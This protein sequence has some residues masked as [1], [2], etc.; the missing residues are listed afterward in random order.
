MLST[1]VGKFLITV[2]FLM[3]DQFYIM[4]SVNLDFVTCG[5][6]SYF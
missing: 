5:L 3:T 4:K 2:L 1:A 6:H